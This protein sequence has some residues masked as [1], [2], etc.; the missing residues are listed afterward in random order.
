MAD[1]GVGA[2]DIDALVFATMTPDYYAPGSAPIAQQL[3]GLGPVP[4][5]GIRQ[6]CS[7]FLYGLDLA[8]ALLK[9]GKAGRVLVIGAE[10]HAGIQPWSADWRAMKSGQPI[11]PESYERNN[12]YRG[13]A[14]LFGDGAGAVVVEKGTT[15]TDGLLD[16]ALF[17]DGELFE[18]IHVP[19][20]GSRSQP[21]VDA[22][23]VAADEHMPTM[24]GPML[25]RQA[26]R[27]MPEAVAG[28]LER[29]G[30]ETDDVDIVI[31][32]QANRRIVEGV[33]KRLGLPDDKVPMN[34]DRYG[35]TTAGTLPILYHEMCEAG[36]IGPGALVAFV[37]FGAGAH[38]GAALYRVPS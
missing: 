26:V 15:E 6:Q 10:V 37:A 2:D 32:H 28:L 17:T 4:A 22:A 16:I 31:A 27:R 8:D 24:Q 23:T 13:W 3:L 25:Y 29:Q 7:G 18:L 35:N 11:T 34:M 38:W 14:V 30:L 12:K 5:Y 1:A 9:A 36:R 20:L 19:A 21:L 33:Q